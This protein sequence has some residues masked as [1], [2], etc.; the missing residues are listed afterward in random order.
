MTEPSRL[1]ASCVGRRQLASEKLYHRG[2]VAAPAVE[3]HWDV[4]PVDEAH[5]LYVTLVVAAAAAV[6]PLVG[7]LLLLL[8]CML[9]L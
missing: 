2:D 9:L 1:R 6:A 7:T 4:A 3:L 8:L 5:W